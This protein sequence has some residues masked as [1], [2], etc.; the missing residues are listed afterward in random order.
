MWKKIFEICT[1]L[2]YAKNAKYAAITCSHETD[3]PGQHD[4]MSLFLLFVV[5]VNIET[6]GTNFF[7]SLTGR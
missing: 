2:K 4:S 5:F 3:M 1:S 6:T 7:Y